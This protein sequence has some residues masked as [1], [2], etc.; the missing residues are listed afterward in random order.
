MYEV[1]LAHLSRASHVSSD[2]LD[3]ICLENDTEEST[4]PELDAATSK[5][6]ALSLLSRIAYLINIDLDNL[7]AQL[8]PSTTKTQS[9]DSPFTELMS[10]PSGTLV[11]WGN[12][13]NKNLLRTGSNRFIEGVPI[14]TIVNPLALS[15]LYAVAVCKLNSNLWFD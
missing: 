7:L 8:L 10:P 9:L 11:K 14:L 3:A 13:I 5:R 2:Y 12:I 4:L 1:N 6:Y 15:N